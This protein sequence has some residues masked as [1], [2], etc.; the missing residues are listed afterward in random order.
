MQQNIVQVFQHLNSE[1]GQRKRI[2]CYSELSKH[3]STTIF[4][5]LNVQYTHNYFIEHV[6]ILLFFYLQCFFPFDFH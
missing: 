6:M 5:Y 3:I 2:T 4:K 1:F